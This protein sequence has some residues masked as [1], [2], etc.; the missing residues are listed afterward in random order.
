MKKANRKIAAMMSPALLISA[1][2][3]VY[4]D[5]ST[6]V[7]S[8]DSSRITVQLSEEIARNEKEL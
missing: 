1:F 6:P 3:A 5:K 4:T 7:F 2:S 8:T